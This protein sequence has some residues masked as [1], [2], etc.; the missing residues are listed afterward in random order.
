MKINS[1]T[2]SIAIGTALGVGIGVALNNFILGLAIGIVFAIGLI[3]KNKASK[4][5]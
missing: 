5:N 1:E 4:E 2:K 3:N